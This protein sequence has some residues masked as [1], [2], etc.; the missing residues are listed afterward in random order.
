MGNLITIDAIRPA[1]RTGRAP[2]GMVQRLATAE[3]ISLPNSRKITLVFSDSSVDRMGDK[4]VAAGWETH[5]YLKNP[6]VL[7]AHDA[8]APPIGRAG[9][10]R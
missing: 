5:N 1:L 2:S 7:W 4:I 6:V 3:P 10:V 8:S 9:N